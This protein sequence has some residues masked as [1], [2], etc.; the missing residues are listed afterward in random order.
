M[1]AVARDLKGLSL[2]LLG[3]ERHLLTVIGEL[4]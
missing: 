2:S 4:S 1:P 3:Y